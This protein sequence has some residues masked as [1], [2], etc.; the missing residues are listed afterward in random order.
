MNE[1][2]KQNVERNGRFINSLAREIDKEMNVNSSCW[3]D[4][5]ET[6]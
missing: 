3:I 5:K 1:Y 6:E 2:I 4:R